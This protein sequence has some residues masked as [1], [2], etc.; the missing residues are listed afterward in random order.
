MKSKIE[1]LAG[2]F[3]CNV[4]TLP[5]TYLLLLLGA[6][7]KFINIWQ[8]VVV[9]SEELARW[10]S[11]YLSVGHR[12]VPIKSVLDSLSTYV[13]SIFPLLV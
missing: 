9:R 12:L 10:K 6:K 1:A 7:N 5:T 3:G 4:R 2:V 8:R 13:M 11:Q